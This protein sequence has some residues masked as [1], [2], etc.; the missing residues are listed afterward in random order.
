LLR[1]DFLVMTQCLGWRSDEGASS[2]LAGVEL[3][4][5]IKYGQLDNP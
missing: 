2:T 3:W 4:S 1:E 5:I